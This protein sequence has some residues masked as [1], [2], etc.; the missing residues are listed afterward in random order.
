MKKIIALLG[1][2]ALIF[3]LAA[4]QQD[5]SLDNTEKHSIT[6]NDE[7]WLYEKIPSA[8]KAGEPVQVKIKFATD[9]GYLFLVNGD[10]VNMTNNTNEYW[11]FS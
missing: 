6:M 11:L 8:A 3:S 10:E 2:L 9:L 5:G 1:L 4:C 7:E